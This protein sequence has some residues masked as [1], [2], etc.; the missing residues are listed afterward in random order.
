MECQFDRERE[1]VFERSS[2]GRG[3]MGATGERDPTMASAP[4]QTVSVPRP[5]RRC[6]NWDLTARDLPERRLGSGQLR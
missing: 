6:L 2:R 5:T 3:R 1:R 4:S